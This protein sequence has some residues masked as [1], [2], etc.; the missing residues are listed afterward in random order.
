MI[1]RMLTVFF[2][3]FWTIQVSAHGESSLGPHGG[4]IKMPGGFHTEIVKISHFKFKV[5]LLDIAFKSPIVENSKVTAT[6]KFK[7]GNRVVECQPKDDFF[8]CLLPESIKGKLQQIVLQAKRAEMIG[9]ESAYEYP[10]RF[11]KK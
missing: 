5:Y 3:L 7:S 9:V 10:L 2:S 8:L 11:N 4:Y 1:T 6:F